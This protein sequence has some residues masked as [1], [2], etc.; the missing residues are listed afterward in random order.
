MRNELL[1]ALL[2]SLVLAGPASA[3]SSRFGVVVNYVQ[4]PSV[5]IVKSLAGIQM[6]TNLQGY[7]NYSGNFWYSPLY[8]DGLGIGTTYVSESCTLS[9]VQ[10]P[11]GDC[12][13]AP[14]TSATTQPVKSGPITSIATAPKLDSGDLAG[15]CAAG[16]LWNKG[17][18]IQIDNV[19]NFTLTFT[20]NE[21]FDKMST[22]SYISGGEHVH[23]MYPYQVPVTGSVLLICVDSSV[24]QDPSTLPLGAGGGAP[25]GT[26]GISGTPDQQNQWARQHVHRQY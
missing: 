2:G 1:G 18:P 9:N 15:R 21:G 22:W 13:V 10:G 16:K 17:A 23:E 8:V 7:I 14:I 20:F 6:M 26:T 12:F 5:T 24:G 11:L 4:K 3:D 19:F 25:P